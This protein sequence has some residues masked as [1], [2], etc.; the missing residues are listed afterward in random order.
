MM[1]AVLDLRG[2]ADKD[3]F[4]GNGLPQHDWFETAVV[5]LSG[6][7]DQVIG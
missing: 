5:A 6:Q 1:A 7:Q 4:F 2:S 3:Y